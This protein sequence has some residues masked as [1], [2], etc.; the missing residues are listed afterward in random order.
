MDTSS[1]HDSTGSRD[2]LPKHIMVHATSSNFPQYRLKRC[3]R[4]ITAAGSF[5]GKRHTRLSVPYSIYSVTS[6]WITRTLGRGRQLHPGNGVYYPISPRRCRVQNLL[7]IFTL[8]LSLPYTHFNPNQHHY[9]C[10]THTSIQTKIVSRQQ[11]NLQS[12]T[13]TAINSSKKSTISD[14]QELPKLT[15]LRQ[16]V[17]GVLAT[18]CGDRQKESLSTVLKLHT[19]ILS[20][21]RALLISPFISNQKPEVNSSF[22]RTRVPGSMTKWLPRG[23][24]D[25]PLVPFCNRHIYKPIGRAI[26]MLDAKRHELSALRECQIQIGTFPHFDAQICYLH[27]ELSDHESLDQNPRYRPDPLAFPHLLGRVE[28]LFHKVEHEKATMKSFLADLVTDSVQQTVAITPNATPKKRSCEDSE[29]DERQALEH[30]NKHPKLSGEIIQTD[31]KKRPRESDSDDDTAGET[32]RSIKRAKHHVN[33]DLGSIDDTAEEARRSIKSPK[34]PVHTNFGAGLPD[35]GSCSPRTSPEPAATELSNQEPNTG[36]AQQPAVRTLKLLPPSKP[37]ATEPSNEQLI[38]D[39]RPNLDLF[40][41]TLSRG[42]GLH[43]DNYDVQEFERMVLRLETQFEQVFEDEEESEWGDEAE[44][45]IL[46]WLEQVTNTS[47]IDSDSGYESS[48]DEEEDDEEDEEEV[49]AQ[50][51]RDAYAATPALAAVHAAFQ[52]EHH[53]DCAL[54]KQ[55]AE[56]EEGLPFWII[57]RDRTKNK[58]LRGRSMQ[59]FYA[60][61]Q[62]EDV[63]SGWRNL[64]ADMRL[65]LSRQTHRPNYNGDEG[66]RSTCHLLVCERHERHP[67]SR[68]IEHALFETFFWKEMAHDGNEA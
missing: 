23:D 68:V 61:R 20:R 15:K 57:Q 67:I 29:E 62:S 13:T 56:A 34:Q 30:S 42:L 27:A 22:T 66:Q 26:K 19:Q 43:W 60:A 44:Q 54:S 4:P 45:E 64:L 35:P 58:L 48:D 1:Q 39:E 55:I 65:A 52:V 9:H 38:E 59:K 49:Q 6:Y 2:Q 17:N 31:P 41:A 3:V 53:R 46:A 47:A 25:G 10:H 36:Q 24:L 7:G 33:A 63:G 16:Q 12:K 40:Y 51:L 8:F 14:K 5:Q 37:V 21:L 28:T 18:S 32:G 11:H 50:A